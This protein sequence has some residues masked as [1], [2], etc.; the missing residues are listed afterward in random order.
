MTCSSTAHRGGTAP[1]SLRKSW[2]FALARRYVRYKFARGFDGVHVEGLQEARALMARE[3]VIVA[4]THVAWWDALFAIQMAALLG[5][6]SYCLMDA[7]NLRRLPFF[8]W[9][10]AVPLD[11]SSPKRALKDMKAAA[12]LL[13]RPGRVVWIFPQGRQRPALT[14]TPGVHT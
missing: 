1:G 11:R 8:G 3:P 7:A 14:K 10:G 5:G 13:D 12:T 4:A 6:E 2:F 9:V